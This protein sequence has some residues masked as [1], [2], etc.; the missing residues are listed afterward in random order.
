VDS[1]LKHRPV[2]GIYPATYSEDARYL[3]AHR[4]HLALQGHYALI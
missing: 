4:S 1:N 2:P 3:T